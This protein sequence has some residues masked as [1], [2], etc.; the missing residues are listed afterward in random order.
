[1][2]GPESFQQRRNAPSAVSVP[3]AVRPCGAGPESPVRLSQE[4][5]SPVTWSE[6]EYRVATREGPGPP[7]VKETE[8]GGGGFAVI[9][10][11]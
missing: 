6:V 5:E 8:L 4:A 9:A 1:V 2:S 7:D 3:A 10:A 11:A